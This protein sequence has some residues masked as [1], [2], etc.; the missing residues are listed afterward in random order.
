MARCYHAR[1]DKRQAGGTVGKEDW[2]RNVFWDPWTAAVFER[3][4]A[5]KRSKGQYLRIQASY[6]TRTSPWAA[7]RLLERYFALKDPSDNARAYIDQ[8]NAHLT[9]GRV[10]RAID[11]LRDGVLHEQA[12]GHRRR[13]G[14]SVAFARLV[15][16][17]RR[18]DL[19]E[20]ALSFLD[21][22]QTDGGRTF[23]VEQYRRHGAR[24][25]LLAAAGRQAEAIH[26]ARLAIEAAGLRRSWSWKHPTL[27][28]VGP[29]LDGFGR[30][31]RA[32]AFP[33]LA[34]P[35]RLL[36]G[37]G[38]VAAPQRPSSSPLP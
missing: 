4:L 16:I 2:Y 5:R 13:A 20:E 24:A 33:E 14:A 10:E 17:K 9:L 27:G 22:D 1:R 8:S 21:K 30:R 23:P 31:I 34:A 28:L 25:L 19:A 29:T 12:D 6:L 7:L 3:R 18:W 36:V 15:A 38:W 37:L 35:V 11:S 32:V 26:D